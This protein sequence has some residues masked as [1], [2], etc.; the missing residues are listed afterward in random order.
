MP[1]KM[2]Y[3]RQSMDRQA[4]EKE[5]SLIIGQIKK[6]VPLIRPFFEL[7]MDLASY[8]RQLYD[9]EVQPAHKER[10]ELVKR[11]ITEKIQKLFG[12][13]AM[14]DLQVNLDAKLAFNIA[15]HHMVLSHPFL[16][17]ANIVSSVGKFLQA[18]KQDAIIV[19]SSGDIP[20]NNYFSR[21]GFMFHG[22]RVPLFSVSEREYTSYFIPSREFDL[23][24]RLKDIGRWK[25]FSPEEQGFLID[26]EGRMRSFDYSGCDNYTDQMTVAVKNTWPLMFAES[27][28]KTLPELIYITQEELIT[29]CLI[30]ILQ[31]DNCI[32]KAVFDPKFREMVLNNFRGIVTTWRES[33][34]KGTHF[35]W[36]KYPGQPRSL[37]M[38]V[39]G[40][41]LVPHDQRF[42][43][44]SVPFERGAII[45]LLRKREIYPGLFLI[46]SVLNFY[47]GV[48]PLV[49][50]GS[51][52]YLD[53]I[54]NAWLRTLKQ[55]GMDEEAR[56]MSGIETSALVAGLALIFKKT[57]DKVGPMYAHDIFFDGGI[58][59]EYLRQI[60]KMRFADAFSVGIA[61][62]YDY[63]SQKY[64]PPEEKIKRTVG[65]LDLASVVFDWVK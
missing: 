21:S 45:D 59:E 58:T 46:F 9:F 23:V 53:F 3:Y 43:N 12:E 1:R 48:K 14:R 29:E 16:I 63:Y 60:F 26:E 32:S 6:Y 22:K 8:S 11:K 31:E 20:P 37:R 13:R 50:F 64:V 17:S 15:D 18:K 28:R 40:D 10:Q 24:K 38:F 19:I 62:M 41:R 2:I 56:L 54:K 34:G 39:E 44:L 36:R 7:K 55:A 57:N 65:F 49:G 47:C 30:E 51:A 5:K 33:E 25:E 61:D 35:F 4:I 42:A 27:M 52:V